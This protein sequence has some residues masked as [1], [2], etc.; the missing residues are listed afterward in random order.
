MEKII[1][2]ILFVVALYSIIGVLFSL[3]FI[4]KGLIKTDPSAKG[5]GVLF[6]FLIFPGLIIFWPLFMRK[7][8]K[9]NNR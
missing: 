6:K 2:S 5:S 8:I 9:I 1:T 3:I 4:W 7:W